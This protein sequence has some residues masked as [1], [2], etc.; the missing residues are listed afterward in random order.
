VAGAA[1]ELGVQLTENNGNNGTV[2]WRTTRHR[3]DQAI[4]VFVL[5]ARVA[6]RL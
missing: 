6:L 2:R 3:D 5:D 1:F 4:P